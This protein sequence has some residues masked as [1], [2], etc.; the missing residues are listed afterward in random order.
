MKPIDRKSLKFFK[1]DLCRC[2][3][4]KHGPIPDRFY[5]GYW[6]CRRCE[7]FIVNTKKKGP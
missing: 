2:V 5:F 1:D 3:G 4:P 6:I 7:K